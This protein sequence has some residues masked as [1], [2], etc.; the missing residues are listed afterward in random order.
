VDQRLETWWTDL[1]SRWAFRRRSTAGPRRV[2]PRK[3]QEELRGARRLYGRGSPLRRRFQVGC[4]CW[5]IAHRDQMC[6]SNYSDGAHHQSS[7]T[8]T[9]RARG[10]LRPHYHKY[11][12]QH[13]GLLQCHLQLTGA[14]HLITIKQLQSTD[15]YPNNFF[16]HLL[17]WCEIR[18]CVNHFFIFYFYKCGTEE[19]S[20]L[21]RYAPGH[22]AQQTFLFQIIS[23]PPRLYSRITDWTGRGSSTYNQV[24]FI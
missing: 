12:H 20:A 15:I 22:T 2:G 5:R 4:C 6:V 18:E 13:I 24:A 1:I 23:P 9:G 17:T 16:A 19:V 11:H 10:R 8:H 3:E 14:P 21:D 7:H